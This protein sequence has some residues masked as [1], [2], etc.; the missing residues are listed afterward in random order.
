MIEESPVLPLVRLDEEKPCPIPIWSG[1][2]LS[3]LLRGL[4]PFLGVQ[5]CLMLQAYGV[6]CPSSRLG[7]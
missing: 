1:P 3:S 2:V 6:A 7:F 5:S 4:W